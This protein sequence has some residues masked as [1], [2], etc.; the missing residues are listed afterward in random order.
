MP[1]PHYPTVDIDFIIAQI[2]ATGRVIEGGMQK[3]GSTTFFTLDG[4][5]PIHKR[6]ILIRDIGGGQINFEQATGLAIKYYFLESLMEWLK[7]HR[8]YKEGAY[9]VDPL[10]N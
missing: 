3:V 6:H 5:K 7:K 9:I 10:N 1:D 2:H 8:N 4:N